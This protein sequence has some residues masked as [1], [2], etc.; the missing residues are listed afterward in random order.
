[1]PDGD[2]QL[3]YTSSFK[4]PVLKYRVVAFFDVGSCVAMQHAVIP[5]V[6]FDVY[7]SVVVVG[8]DGQKGV[9]GFFAGSNADEMVGNYTD[10]EAKVLGVFGAKRQ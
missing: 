7:D 6:D 5:L 4:Q 9:E 10:N 1:M 2:A 8:K 3:S